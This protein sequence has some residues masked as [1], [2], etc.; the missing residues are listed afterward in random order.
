MLFADQAYATQI[1]KELYNEAMLPVTKIPQTPL[2]LNEAC[3]RLEE[4]ILEQTIEHGNNP[5]LN[6]NVANASLVRG[7][8]GLIYPDKSSATERIDGL[9]AL[10]NAIAAAVAD[11]NDRGPSVYETRGV[12]T[13]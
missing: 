4:M 10:I 12:L 7:T 9:S 11:P 6:W 5:I 1:L 2:R 13:V 8:T 3:V